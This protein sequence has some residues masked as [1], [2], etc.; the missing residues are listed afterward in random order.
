MNSFA[1][2]MSIFAV[3]FTFANC[4]EPERPQPGTGAAFDPGV[5][6]KANWRKRRS[7]HRHE[8]ANYC[9]LFPATRY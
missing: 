9:S 6:L 5:E 7:R 8:F 4:G 3:A 2:S 1:R